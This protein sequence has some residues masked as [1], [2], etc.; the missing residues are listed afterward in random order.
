MADEQPAGATPAEQGATPNTPDPADTGQLGAA[1][2]SALQ[3]EREQRE[4]AEKREKALAKEL[5]AYQDKDKSE[6]EKTAERITEL[7]RERDQFAS[8]RREDSL[9][10]AAMTAARKLGYR[11]PDLAFRLIATGAVDYDEAGQPRNVERLLDEIAK[12]D[13]YLVGNATD[14]GG[15]PRGKA[16]GSDTDMNSL[17]RKAAGRPG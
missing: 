12:A 15:G 9:R 5:K 10:I 8:A 2:L 13:P 4:A 3:R 16:S 6:S 1:G 11:N 14:Y 7:E 17:I